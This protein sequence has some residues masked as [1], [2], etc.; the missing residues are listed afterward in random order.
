MQ[1]PDPGRTES[2]LRIAHLTTKIKMEGR[3]TSGVGWGVGCWD[4]RGWEAGEVG[5]QVEHP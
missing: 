4:W 2:G 1:A 5:K 3:K